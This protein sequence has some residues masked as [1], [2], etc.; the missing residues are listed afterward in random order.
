MHCW[1]KWLG[2]CRCV[3]ELPNHLF[4]RNENTSE[5][6]G[7]LARCF[8]FIHRSIKIRPVSVKT[9]DEVTME[10]GTDD[11]L[12]VSHNSIISDL[13][14]AI[15]RSTRL[16][17]SGFCSEEFVTS[18]S[19]CHNTCSLVSIWQNTSV[20]LCSFSLSLN[21]TFTPQGSESSENI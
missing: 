17:V 3:T 8:S 19:F 11:N 13:G 20:Q 15:W 4:K 18:F 14:S 16:C 7:D 12:G 21:P 10:N 2:S 1:F 9:F 5:W 6:L